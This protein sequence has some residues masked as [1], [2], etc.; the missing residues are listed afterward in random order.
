M[1]DTIIIDF[2]GVIGTDS[3]TIFIETLK[4]N[5]FT[6]EKAKEIWRLHWPNLKVGLEKIDTFWK[7]VA[8]KTEVSISK[9]INEYNDA[10]A[11]DENILDLCRKLKNNNYKLGILANESLEWMDIKRNK[12]NLGKIFD[13]VYSSAD[14]KTAK[15]DP[16]SYEL[17]LDRIKSK[18]ENTLFV[19]NMERNIKAAEKLGIKSIVFKEIDQL[20]KELKNHSIRI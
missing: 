17:I 14:L 20:K 4:N 11:V 7:T 16:K 15:P 5:G 9:I 10:I 13:V 1:I 19:D 18:P 3:D 2:G 12:G 8:E 6:I